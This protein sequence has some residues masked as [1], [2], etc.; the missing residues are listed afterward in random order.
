MLLIR[1][2]DRIRSMISKQKWTDE[3]N[4]IAI[5]AIATGYVGNQEI[6]ESNETNKNYF[7][8]QFL[9]FKTYLPKASQDSGT[10]RLI[11]K[12]ILC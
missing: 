5:E 11:S 2:S 8:K 10:N 12:Y 1:F 3:Q 4:N 6:I 7:K 9:F